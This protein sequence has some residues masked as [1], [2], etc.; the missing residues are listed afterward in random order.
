[1]RY[2][3]FNIRQ[4]MT[5][6]FSCFMFKAKPPLGIVPI[7]LKYYPTPQCNVAH[8]H[9]VVQTKLRFA[10]IALEAA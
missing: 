6:C 8:L 4:L 9:L 7:D 10:P 2:L 5:F 3:D 1:M